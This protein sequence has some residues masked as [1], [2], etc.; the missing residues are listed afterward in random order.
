MSSAVF[1]CPPGGEGGVWG[2]LTHRRNIILIGFPTFGAQ[3]YRVHGSNKANGTFYH[4][5][6]V[7]LL[8]LLRNQFTETKKQRMNEISFSFSHLLN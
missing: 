3:G 1:C 5:G 6:L 4:R 2:Y 8:Q 7:Q